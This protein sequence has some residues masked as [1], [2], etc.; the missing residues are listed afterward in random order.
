MPKSR[1]RG[2]RRRPNTT[3][4]GTQARSGQTRKAPLAVPAHG[5]LTDAELVAVQTIADAMGALPPQPACTGPLLVHATG[6][7]ECHGAGCPG[8]LAIFHSDDVVEPC[9]LHPGIRTRHACPRCLAH[10]D[11]LVELATQTC[12]GVQIDHDDDIF[13]CTLG[14]ACLG[15]DA[16]HM[17]SRTC[18]ASGSCSRDCRWPGQDAE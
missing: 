13:E 16:I 5:A 3:R 2:G 12:T 15:K 1:G 7:F 8:G 9:T 14:D 4:S 6:V 17:S 11:G 18:R 10:S